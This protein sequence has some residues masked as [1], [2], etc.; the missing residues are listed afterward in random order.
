MDIKYLNYIIEI[1]EQKNITHAA[2]NLF[3]SQSTLSQH[4]A[5]I[6]TELKTPLFTRQKS[7]LELTEAGKLYVDS[8]K[9]VVNIQKNLYKNIENLS[10]RGK[11][12]VG[13]TSLWGMEMLTDI[14]PLFQKKFPNITIEIDKNKCDKLL[15]NIKTGKID[16]AI[17]AVTE[18]DYSI[19][20]HELLREEE[21]VLVTKSDSDKMKFFEGKT[22]ITNDEFINHFSNDSFILSDIGST[23]RKVT[24]RFFSE[25][26][27]VPK[28]ICE[29]NNNDVILDMVSK[30]DCSSF[31]PIMYAKNRED[32]CYFNIIPKI[33]RI[34][35]L[36]VSTKANI[37]EP[38]RYLI[39]LIRTYK[40]FL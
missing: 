2:E 12:K 5:K 36:S 16:I 35:I 30:M 32:L 19:N 34:N 1:A 38:E 7:S 25:N 18:D 29:I 9:T 14:L 24:N 22:S 20:E 33:K 23:L 11:I 15:N 31:I 21:I 6:E 13:I 28:I 3:V 8:A 27:L 4:L 26:S 10:S 39:E 17:V 40:L 37:L